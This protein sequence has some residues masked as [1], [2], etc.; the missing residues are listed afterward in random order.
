MTAPALIGAPMAIAL[1]TEP[2]TASASPYDASVGYSGPKP[3]PMSTRARKTSSP[4]GP[5]RTKTFGRYQRAMDDAARAIID[6][7]LRESAGN[8]QAA[9]AW[10]GLT[11]VGLWKLMRTHGIDAARYRA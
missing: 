9:A 11:R 2:Q 3:T 7:A 10:L 8:V 4:R 1:T 5:V 6:E